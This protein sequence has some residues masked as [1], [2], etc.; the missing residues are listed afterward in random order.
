MGIYFR[1]LEHTVGR[2]HKHIRRDGR[3]R[4]SVSHRADKQHLITCVE[5]SLECWAETLSARML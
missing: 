1:M 5:E 4:R 3:W 2:T